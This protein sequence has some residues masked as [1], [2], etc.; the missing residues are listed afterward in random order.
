MAIDVARARR[1]YLRWLVMLTL[2]NARP[3]SIHEG[4]ILSVAQSEIPDATALELRRELDYLEARALLSLARK[5]SGIWWA[6]LTHLG[7]DVVEYSVDCPPGISRPTRYW[8]S[9]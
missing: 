5:P 9:A 7:M 4:L 1:E 2:N 8:P 6:D 3:E